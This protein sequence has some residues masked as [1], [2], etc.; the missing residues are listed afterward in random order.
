M[1]KNNDSKNTVLLVICVIVLFLLV[2]GV[3]YAAVFYSKIGDKIN[4]VT[5]GSITMS[6]SEKT[7]GINITNAQPTDDE[8]G[9]VL[10]QAN[11]YFD[12]TVSATLTGNIIINYSITATKDTGSSLPDEAIKV[13]LTELNNL[14][15]QEVLL[16]TKISKLSLTSKDISGAPDGEYLLYN[17]NFSSSLSHNYRLRMWVADDY[18]APATSQSY[19]LRVNVY[20]RANAQ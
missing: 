15:E 18:S 8:V 7:N 19:K 3:S 5:T 14:N 10:N 17:G 12:F 6:Y 16:P 1:K 4:T 11:E 13:Y 2:V 20:G 9:K